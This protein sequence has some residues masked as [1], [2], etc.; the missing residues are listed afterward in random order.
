MKT[1]TRNSAAWRRQKETQKNQRLAA[2]KPI[3]VL[4]TRGKKYLYPE[5]RDADGRLKEEYRK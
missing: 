5:R 3:K 2:S 1:Y 4:G